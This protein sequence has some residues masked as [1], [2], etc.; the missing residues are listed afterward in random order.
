[1]V[2]AALKRRRCRIGG[3][4][5]FV[6]NSKQLHEQAGHGERFRGMAGHGVALVGSARMLRTLEESIDRSQHNLG[7][8]AA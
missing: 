5:L 8:R 7:E 2:T 6:M 4:L 3:V 1:M